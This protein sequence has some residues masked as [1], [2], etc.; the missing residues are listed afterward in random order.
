MKLKNIK[1]YIK[2]FGI[3]GTFKFAR[4]ILIDKLTGGKYKR[5][6]YYVYDLE[7]LKDEAP[8]EKIIEVGDVEFVA[9]KDYDPQWFTDK[10]V[11]KILGALNSPDQSAYAYVDDGEIVSYGLL[12]SKIRSND[13]SVYPWG[14]QDAYLWDDYTNPKFRGQG[15]HRKIILH[16]LK[17]AKEMG[18]RYAWSIVNDYN[19]P[20]YKNFERM[21]F[22]KAFEV[23]S[24]LKKKSVKD[25]R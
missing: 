5:V 21:G 20:S 12:N 16:R 8:D 9:A 6:S 14:E 18:K 19:R 17:K 10:K 13:E 24:F 23:E 25:I 1:N 3:G 11:N 4:K 2:K 7:N 22:K 15:L